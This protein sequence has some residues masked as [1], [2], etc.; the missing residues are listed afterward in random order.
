MKATNEMGINL[1]KII[2]HPDVCLYADQTGDLWRLVFN[3]DKI[4]IKGY[5][6]G[7]FRIFDDSLNTYIQSVVPCH[8][9]F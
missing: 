2:H 7:M 1:V 4:D 3:D 8:E 9:I 6:D 5:T